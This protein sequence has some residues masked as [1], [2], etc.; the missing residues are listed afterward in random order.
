[1]KN[2]SNGINM[3]IIMFDVGSALEVF[4]LRFDAHSNLEGAGVLFLFSVIS[5]KRTSWE[6]SKLADMKPLKPITQN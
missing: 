6:E 3:G 2:N 5:R 4:Y 1:M